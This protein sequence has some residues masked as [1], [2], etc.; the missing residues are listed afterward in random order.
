MAVLRQ[1]EGLLS[2]SAPLLD[3]EIIGKLMTDLAPYISVGGL[4][5]NPDEIEHSGLQELSSVT[6]SDL[7]KGRTIFR[8]FSDFLELGARS[9]P[10]F[11]SLA[12]PI[13]AEACAKI[14]KSLENTDEWSVVYAA[15]FSI[16]ACRIRLRDQNKSR[17]L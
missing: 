7:K 17:P 15:M 10:I 14:T 3:A 4:F 2:Q 12:P 6:A 8:A 5:G 1:V 11:P 16:V 9:L 13:L